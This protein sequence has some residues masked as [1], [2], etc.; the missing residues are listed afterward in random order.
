MLLI[1]FVPGRCRCLGAV[2]GGGAPCRRQSSC[3]APCK[4]VPGY[5]GTCSP[6]GLP[7]APAPAPQRP[8]EPV[9][10]SLAWAAWPGR[11]WLA[12][13]ARAGKRGALRVC[14]LRFSSDA[15]SYC[16]L[17]SE[18]R[19]HAL[20]GPACSAGLGFPGLAALDTKGSLS[21]GARH[22]T[23][24]LLAQPRPRHHPPFCRSLRV[25][26]GD[27]GCDAA[28]P[29]SS[30]PQ[31]SSR[32][33]ERAERAERAALSS[34]LAHFLPFCPLCQQTGCDCTACR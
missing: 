33:A 26:A 23:C 12:W 3:A 17:P 5:G 6:T 1:Y 22:S 31:P 16:N 19:R 24:Y 8:R 20:H 14:S 25:R 27:V 4:A 32:Q 21:S 7:Q 11:A 28:V 15:F 2:Q 9:D 13:L 30:F 34:A 18:V 10:S 29:E